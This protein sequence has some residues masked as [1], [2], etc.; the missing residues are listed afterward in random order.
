MTPFTAVLKFAAEEVTMVAFIIKSR[1]IYIDPS[2]TLRI[3][4]QIQICCDASE[5]S[6]LATPICAAGVVCLLLKEG[7]V[8]GTLHRQEQDDHTHYDQKDLCTVFFFTGLD[9]SRLINLDRSR[10]D[11]ECSP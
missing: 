9:R 2:E 4:N 10:F 6:D 1:S 3:H 11:Y 8:C 5:I 7:V